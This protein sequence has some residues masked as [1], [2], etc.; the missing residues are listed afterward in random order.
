MGVAVVPVPPCP[1]LIAVVKPVSEVMSEFAPEPA[2]LRLSLAPEALVAPVP[3]DAIASVPASVSVPEVVMGVPVKER[4]VVPPDAA[5]DV[6]VPAP[7][8]DVMVMPPALFVMLM[9]DP[10]VRVAFVSVLPVLLPMS[11]CPSVYV[12]WPVPPLAT[13]SAVPDSEIASV[14]EVVIGEP[15]TD[16]NDGTVAATLVTEPEPVPTPTPLMKRPVALIVPTPRA[17]SVGVPIWMPA[18]LVSAVMSAF[19]PLAAAP[20]FVR[21]P[22]AVVEPVPPCATVRAVVRPVS[23]VMSLFAPAAAAEMVDRALAAEAAVKSAAP[24]PVAPKLV[25]AEVAL[26]AP[27]PPCSTGKMPA[28]GADVVAEMM[29]VPSQYRMAVSP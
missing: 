26:F 22:P 24:M 10:A 15:V 27:V 9:P 25:R 2:A 7:A 29:F 14:P 16:R 8:V 11:N 6:T 21:A 20:R 3:P 17:P 13:G 12:V 4:P 1:T 23:D 5:T 19:E 28:N 18:A